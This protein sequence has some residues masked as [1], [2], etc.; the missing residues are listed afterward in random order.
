MTPVELGI[1]VRATAPAFD[2]DV[3]NAGKHPGEIPPTTIVGCANCTEP[4]NWGSAESGDIFLRKPQS[5]PGFSGLESK[6]TEVNG[7]PLVVL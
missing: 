1:L 5:S 3:L 2:A 6:P 7:S 4:Y